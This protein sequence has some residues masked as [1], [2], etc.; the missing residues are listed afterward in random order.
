[1][2]SK[3][4]TQGICALAHYNDLPAVMIWNR[5]VAAG[6][7]DLGGVMKLSDV[8]RTVE[9]QG[10]R[11]KVLSE[12]GKASQNILYDSSPENLLT[13]WAYLILFIIIYAFVTVVFL[14]FIDR[15]KR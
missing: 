7:V 6:N 11:E 8:M 12:L 10:M 14:E 5:L 13:C 9:E 1:M 3:W 15:D 4:G 2:I